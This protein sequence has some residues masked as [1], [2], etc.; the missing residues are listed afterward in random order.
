MVC[1]WAGDRRGWQEQEQLG[2]EVSVGAVH[3]T[4][5][6]RCM[7]NARALRLGHQGLV[8]A[9]VHTVHSGF[10]AT[11][12]TVLCTRMLLRAVTVGFRMPTLLWRATV[13]RT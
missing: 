3:A 2:R 8:H 6:P 5:P 13:F 9:L 10:S 12:T 4:P 1:G 7:L 11:T